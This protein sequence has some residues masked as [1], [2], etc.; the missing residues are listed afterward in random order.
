[1][2]VVHETVVRTLAAQRWSQNFYSHLKRDKAALQP[3]RNQHSELVLLLL[4]T[5]SSHQRWL[6]IR[7]SET[8]SGLGYEFSVG[9]HGDN[10]R[11]KIEPL[12]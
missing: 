10:S 4:W 12:R 11:V 7:T 9:C 1:M 8:S 3:I 5:D 6:P 2:K